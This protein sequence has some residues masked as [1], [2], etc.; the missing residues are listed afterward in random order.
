MAK[1]MSAETS[2]RVLDVVRAAKGPM[3]YRE[4]QI[5]A[6]LSSSNVAHGYVL[7]LADRGLVRV[8]PGRGR[9]IVPVL[10]EGE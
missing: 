9:T 10:K 7:R 5:A 1:T 3:T 4:V 6:G 8:W 2:Q